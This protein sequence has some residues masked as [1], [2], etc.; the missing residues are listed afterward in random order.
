MGGLRRK[1]SAPQ[2]ALISASGWRTTR[3]AALSRG[4]RPSDSATSCC[5]SARLERM[6]LR[7][8]RRPPAARNLSSRPK[9]GQA[10]V[11]HQ[12]RH[13]ATGCALALARASRFAC[14]N[15]RRKTDRP[16][17]RAAI[18]RCR[19]GCRVLDKTQ[20]G[21]AIAPIRPS[22]RN[23]PAASPGASQPRPPLANIVAWRVCINRFKHILRRHDIMR[24]TPRGGCH[25]APGRRE[26]A[27]DLGFLPHAPRWQ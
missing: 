12:Q 10:D 24:R 15:R 23:A 5:A 25:H 26:S 20:L 16:P 2:K 17:R 7:C 19:T 22:D 8:P 13:A 27:Y 11:A 18:A 1:P 9:S 4:N 21:R 14:R 6:R 3:C